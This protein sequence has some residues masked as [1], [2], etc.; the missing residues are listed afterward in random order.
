MPEP[1]ISDKTSSRLTPTPTLDPALNPTSSLPGQL[2]ANVAASTTALVRL[3]HAA[4]ELTLFP[5]LP[6]RAIMAGGHRSRLRGRGMDFDEVRPYQPGDDGR[7][8]DWRVTARTTQTYT[9]V[10]REERERPVMLVCDLRQSMFFGSQ[11]TKSVT[12][13]EV[14]AAL[15]WAALNAGDRIGGLVFAPTGQQDIRARRSHHSVLQL[16]KTL[17]DTSAS[18]VHRQPDNYSLTQILEHIRRVAHPGSAVVIVSDFYDFDRDGERHLFEL[19]R[20]CDVTLCHIRDDLD[21]TLPPAGTYSV[22][23]GQR[24]FTLNTRDARVRKAFE[25][26]KHQQTKTLE[27]T[28]TKLRA[29]YLPI[30]TGQAVIPLLQT[31]YGNRA[32]RRRSS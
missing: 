32:A 4:K 8:I 22:S 7:S 13:C 25:L 14:T 11:K 30:R 12:A 21:I 5:R 20:H 15:A 29:T 18:L 23:D 19:S 2:R 9:K 27:Q 6:P 1:G 17:A 16:I 31:V 10:F 3:R 26:R 24:R 28:T